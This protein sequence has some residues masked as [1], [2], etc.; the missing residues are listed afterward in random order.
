MITPTNPTKIIPVQK[1][2]R[3]DFLD[4]LRGIAILFIFMANILTFSGYF[5]FPLEDRFTG[6]TFAF[7]GTFD[8]IMHTLVDG[9][10]YTVFSLL[11]GIGCAM[12][13]YKLDVSN[14]PFA[15]FFRRR[16]FWLLVIGLIHLC[17]FWLGDILTLYALLG[18]V[19]IGFVNF[20][21]RKLIV[22]GSILILFPIANWLFVYVT[23]LNY[24][25]FFFELRSVYYKQQG[26]ATEVW[27]GKTYP[28]FKQFQ[29]N[30]SLLDYFKYNI[31]NTFGRIGAMLEEGRLFKVLGIFI[32]GLWA[33]RKILKGNLLNNS[34]FLKKV[35]IWGFVIGL[36]IST[37][38]TYVVFFGNQEPLWDFIKTVSYALGT[39]PLAI[40]IASGLALL[41]RK[42]P[43][44]LNAFAPVG[45]MALSNY[46][47]QT[48]FG[49][50]FFY[51]IGLG[52]AGK[53]GFSIIMAIAIGVFLLQIV[54]SK[55][56]LKHFKFGPVE[57]IW[58][59]LT[60]GKV[61]KILKT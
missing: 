4:V 50:S 42:K 12:Q 32:I 39:V 33:G 41:Y 48:F 56:W 14:K 6:T 25:D 46:L 23:K 19:L 47:F 16:M 38:R 7:D 24:A 37:F 57:W 1:E 26:F 30:E 43:K 11:F 21:D 27:N 28:D 18:F 10:F 44:L 54:L 61:L 40:A 51:G 34:K 59:Q 58:R 60:Y 53:F 8:F 52:Y 2:H 5:S 35:T 45:K 29:S 15:P 36:P 49:V 3:I 9:K 22:F 20:S 55:L 31:G 13:F 17:L